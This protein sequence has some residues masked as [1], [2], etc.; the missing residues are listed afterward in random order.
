MLPAQKVAV[1]ILNYRSAELVSECLSSFQRHTTPGLD[2]VTIVVDGS[3]LQA[4]AIRLREMGRLHG[5]AFLEVSPTG[6]TGEDIKGQN[7][8]FVLCVLES[9]VGYSKGNN[10]GIRMARSLGCDHFILANPDTE[11]LDSDSVPRMVA[12][13]NDIPACVA[14]FPTVRA[15][16]GSTSGNNQGPF[17]MESRWKLMIGPLIWEPCINR[18]RALSRAA[19]RKR[20]ASHGAY[21]I[22]SSLGCFFVAN[23]RKFLEIGGFDERFFLYCEEGVM[24]QRARISGFK[25]FYQPGSTILHKHFYHQKPVNMPL[26]L[27]AKDRML[28]L[29]CGHTP[30]F[31]AAVAARNRLVE[32]LK[33]PFRALLAMRSRKRD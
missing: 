17:F 29:Y 30:G 3:C 11:L 27:E 8:S 16:D 20:H 32:M 10:I 15:P 14:V 18:L 9:N 2:L 25:I 33:T 7:P 1:V 6:Q 24:G 13:L 26:F 12:L 22:H 28:S 5:E 31:L 21:V 23:T 19:S 4:D